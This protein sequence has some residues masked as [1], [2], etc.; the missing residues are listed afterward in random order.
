MN[1]GGLVVAEFLGDVS[2]YSPV[3]ILVYRGGDE[4]WKVF[5]GEFLVDEAWHSLYSWIED[6][7]EVGAILKTKRCLGSLVGYAFAHF[8]CDVVEEVYVFY[9]VDHE[10]V[11]RLEPEGDDVERVVVSHLSGF[12]Q[13]SFI[14]DYEFLVVRHL[15]VE[16]RFERVLE[17]F[18]EYPRNE[19]SDVDWS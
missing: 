1:L 10:G 15:E 19:M 16:P 6:P 18:C 9:V 3:R 8:E 7:A 13:N 2:G 11:F 4:T 17:L 14:V 12:R 5:A